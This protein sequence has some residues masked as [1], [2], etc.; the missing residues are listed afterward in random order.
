VTALCSLSSL[1]RACFALWALAI[2]IVNI[3]SAVLATANRR[4][5]FTAF[6]VLI[7]APV[8]FFWQVIFDI[9]LREKNGYISAA[10]EAVGG[11]AWVWWIVIFVVLTA[12]SV[13]LLVFD[14]RR[15]KT[16]ITPSAIKNYLD[17]VPCGICCFEDSGKVLFANVCMNDLCV[18]ILGS[19]L[20]N[21]KLITD[22]TRQGI[23]T[24][25]DKVWRFAEREIVLGGET[26]HELIASDVTSEYAKTLALEKDKDELSALSEKLHAY[27]LSID[28]TVRRQEIL[29]AKVNI[30][31]EMNKLMLSTMSV[32]NDAE[33]LDRIFSLWEQN[34]LLLC[35]EA[36][37]TAD[38]KAASQVEEL[39]DALKVKLTW[40]TGVPE[41][42]EDIQRTMFFSA[43]QEAIVN[44]VKHA[45]A[46]HVT[47]SFDETAS[48]IVAKIENDGKVPPAG[49]RFTGGLL[50]LKRMFEA[51][52]ASVSVVV[53]ST[54]TL[55]LTFKK[56]AKNQ[57]IG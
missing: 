46:K 36:E 35:M 37:N 23:L 54:F 44:A 55:V 56:S 31:D 15:D 8:Y 10:S 2:I 5:H 12:A 30:H 20:L 45:S 9:S 32:E 52:G 24:I 34:A 47:V 40:Q 13:V 18:S 49:I 4:Y 22:A 50:N 53:G 39:A 16:Y 27:N 6:A 48:E 26:L 41:S 33:E 51:Q 14:V 3:Y 21:G 17:K 7:F 11:M 1:A 29:Q 28:D 57:P 19:P 43:A 38:E 42:F 25:Q